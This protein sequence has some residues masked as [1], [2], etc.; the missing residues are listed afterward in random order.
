MEKL[1]R[2]LLKNFKP[3]TRKAYRSGIRAFLK[4]IYPE[5]KPKIEALEAEQQIEQV[6]ASCL[7]RYFEELP[8]RNF[9]DDLLLFINWL[10]EKQHR[11][12]KTIALYAT[13]VKLFFA[14]HGY[15]I[16]D[17][18]WLSLIHI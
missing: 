8:N 6:Y 17:E 2:W 9:K 18:E 7:E 12:P 5:L 10:T 16:S 4:F 15:P 1:E 14:E 3:R 13:A 11:P